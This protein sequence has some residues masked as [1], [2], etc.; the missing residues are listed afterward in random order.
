MTVL[1]KSINNFIAPLPLCDVV[2]NLSHRAFRNHWEDVVN[3]SIEANVKTLLLTGVNVESSRKSLEMAE[4]HYRQSVEEK[5]NNQDEEV[6]PNL[7]TTVGVHPHDAKTF[8]K[9]TISHMKELIMGTNLA[10]AIGECGLDYNRNFSSREDQMFAF[11]EQV[12]LACELSMPLFVHEREAHSD[13][14]SVLDEFLLPSS[15]SNQPLL[16][17]GKV[18]IHCF[19][20]SIEEARVYVDKGFYIG[21][22]GTICKKE[23]GAHLREIL[24]TNIVPLDKIMVETDCPFMSFVKGRKSSEPAHVVG[25]AKQ[26]SECLGVP[27]ERV[28]EVTMGSTKFF[29]NI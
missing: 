11:R 3:R 7:Y 17:P 15:S 8:D 1:S 20:G 14:L 24:R 5:V 6:S 26:I 21:F 18:L 23:R 10:K 2:V 29:L 27:M 25:V 28:C 19:T 16:C 22:T 12:A 4:T 13:L 9:D